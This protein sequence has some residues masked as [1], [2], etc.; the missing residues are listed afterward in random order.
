MQLLQVPSFHVCVGVCKQVVFSR[1]CIVVAAQLL[2]LMSTQRILSRPW[3]V[4][5]AALCTHSMCDTCDTICDII[6]DIICD[7]MCDIICDRCE[8]LGKQLLAP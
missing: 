1:A 2:R 8:S 5:N 3:H 4:R 6:C 7:T